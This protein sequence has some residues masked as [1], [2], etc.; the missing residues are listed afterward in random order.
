MKGSQNG[1]MEEAYR[2]YTAGLEMTSDLDLQCVFAYVSFCFVLVPVKVSSKGRSIVHV[3]TDHAE[4]RLH[5][6][7]RAPT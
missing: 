5:M 2:F 7:S 4:R 3:Q 1:N 6:L